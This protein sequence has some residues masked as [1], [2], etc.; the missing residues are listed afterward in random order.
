MNKKDGLVGNLYE[1]IVNHT[2]T[3]GSNGSPKIHDCLRSGWWCWA[4]FRE[5]P[6]DIIKF[7]KRKGKSWLK[8]S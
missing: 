6:L 3:V 4:N 2:Y 5:R 8:S 7:I 1:V